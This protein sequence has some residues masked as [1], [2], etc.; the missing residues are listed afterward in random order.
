MPTTTPRPI[1]GS[2]AKSATSLTQQQQ[3]QKQ[4][5]QQQ[6]QQL[7]PSRPAQPVVKRSSGS[8][9]TASP[10][11]PGTNR[12]GTLTKSSVSLFGG[13]GS[14][15]GASPI[16]GPGASGGASAILVPATNLAEVGNLKCIWHA[17][18]GS[19]AVHATAFNDTGD[20]LACGLASG[21]VAVFHPGVGAAGSQDPVAVLLP[22][23]S[24]LQV[25]ATVVAWRPTT[26]PPGPVDMRD[27]ES[28]QPANAP[29]R[30]RDV[31]VAGFPDGQVVAWHAPSGQLLWSLPVVPDNQIFGLEFSPLAPVLVTAGSDC[32]IR[33]YDDRDGIGANG[34]RLVQKLRHGTEDVSAGHTNRIFCVR[35]HPTRP[36][37]LM[38]GG[39]DSTI[40]IWDRTTGTA[41]KSIFRPHVCGDSLDWDADGT[42]ILAG[43]RA[44]AS[45]SSMNFSSSTQTSPS[46]SRGGG[47]GGSSGGTAVTGDGCLN[48]YNA[49]TGALAEGVAWSLLDASGP[50][51][52]CP[53]YTARFSASRRFIVAGGGPGVTAGAFGTNAAP[54]AVSTGGPGVAGTVS[55]SGGGGGGGGG[56]GSVNE[57]K[58]FSFAS[59]RCIAMVAGLQGAVYAAAVTRDDRRVAFAG[60]FDRVYVY[61]LDPNAPQEVIY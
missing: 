18:S 34:H 7:Q 39:W 31:V 1:A 44:T 52:R 14:S 22:P 48:L 50:R 16:S 9:P 59:R 20:L 8:L 6:Q 19:A 13:A 23:S 36:E 38:S 42:R 51:S 33:I 26:A 47:G 25:P 41:I 17:P 27:L 28:V 10:G 54:A 43:S 45:L 11:T 21:R 61:A 55:S 24:E 2:T 30:A 40:Q 32:V 5:Q 35:F 56:G 60:A 29:P 57:L 3:Q 58:V 15:L 37:L 4:Q 53:L 12:K 49:R 46:N